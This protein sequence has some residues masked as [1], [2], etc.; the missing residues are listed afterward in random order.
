MVIEFGM[1]FGLGGAVQ[2]IAKI[3]AQ[4][5]K[6]NV[7]DRDLLVRPIGPVLAGAA[8]GLANAH[9]VG[10]PVTSAG[11]AIGLHERFQQV[12]GMAV[13]V[14]PVGAQTLRHPA[15]DVAGQMRHPNP[16]RNQKTGVVGEP[17]ELLSARGSI[18]PDILV[19]AGALP[20]R[21]AK[22]HASHGP[23]LAVTNQILEIFPDGTSV[24]QVMVLM[25]QR[26]KE[27]TLRSSEGR[28]D[29][30]DEQRK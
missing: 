2:Q 5:I 11:K 30:G 19:P 10:G 14:L 26:F 7:F 9:P 8:F 4:R 23:L 1:V 22:K 15:Q 3:G 29:F 12:N 17:V 13:F 20:S 18:P 25:E 28:T 27:G 16:G 6:V 21:R 24:T